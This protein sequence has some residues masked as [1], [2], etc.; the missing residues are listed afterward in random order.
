[1]VL[2]GG[3]AMKD[4]GQKY[5]LD[6]LNGDSFGFESIVKAY[7]KNLILFIKQYVHDFS[8]AEDISQDV[9]VKLYV[10][11][12]QYSPKSTFKT[13][14]YTIA[15]HEA[16]NY[17]KKQNK[18]AD[19]ETSMLSSEDDDYLKN[20]LADEK[21][22]ALYSALN[23]LNSEYRHVLFLRFFD[24]LSVNEIALLMKKRPRQISDMLYNAKQSLESVILKG[25]IKYEILRSGTK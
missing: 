17:Q 15:K 25:G 1:M 4:C 9:F 6:F 22:K 18:Q 11:K 19:V 16:I 14:L 12:P 21:K 2:E 3:I 7:R 24:D 10:K 20:I 8:I 23:E 5:Y 13:W